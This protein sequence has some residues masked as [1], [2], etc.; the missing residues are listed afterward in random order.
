MYPMFGNLCPDRYDNHLIIKEIVRRYGDAGVDLTS[1]TKEKF[2]RIK[3][4]N[5][6]IFLDSY[7]HLNMSLDKL[8]TNL[9]DKGPEY[10]PLIRKEF[11]N[12]RKFEAC[13][14]KLIYPYSWVDGFDKF[15]QS[16]PTPDKFYNDL[17]DED[18]TPESYQRLL[19]VCKLFDINT[20]GQLHDLYLKIG[21]LI[22]IIDF[23]LI[24]ISTIVYQLFLISL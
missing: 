24:E 20:L 23:L 15:D 3:V 7:S 11:P 19:D 14:Q 9:R 10:F 1:S 8:A 16:I 5:K 6:F 4:G 22:F 2:S 18:I 21:M 12:D 17:K 13:L